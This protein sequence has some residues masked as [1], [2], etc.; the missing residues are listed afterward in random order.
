MGQT[1][2][3][4]IG[5]LSSNAD[6]VFLAAHTPVELDHRK[7]PEVGAGGTGEAKV[8]NALLGRVG[9]LERNTLVAITG[10]S[11]SGKS[12]VVR[13][14]HAQLEKN[15]QRFRILYVPRAVQTI[16]ELL[17]RIIDG[18]PGVEGAELMG[19]VD[20]AI[21][22]ST[23][24][25]MQDRL[26]AEMQ[27]ALNWSLDDQAP[28]EG[29]T[30][31]EA[32]AREDRNNL[33]GE[34]DS[35]GR[36]R[37][38]LADLLE[39]PAINKTLLRSDGNL[40]QL[41]Q[42]Y[43]SET[44]RRDDKEEIFTSD[45][46]PVRERGILGAMKGRPELRE[47]WQIIQRQPDDALDLLEEALRMALPKAL[48]LRAPGGDTLDALF[49]DSRKALRAQNEELVLIFEDLAQFGLIDGEL[50]DQ[51]VT[52]PGGDLA[53]LR[54][55][56]AVTDGAFGKMPPTVRT[57]VEHEFRV[58]ISALAEP[59]AFVGRYLNLVRVGRERTQELWQNR[60]SAGDPVKWIA[61]AC[62]TRE[63]G[64]PCRFKE[65]CHPSFGTVDISGLGEIGLYPYNENALRRAI[66]HVGENATP[67]AVL[68]QCVSEILAEADVH[69]GAGDFPHERTRAQFDFKV[70]MAKQPLLE[71]NPSSDPERAYRAIVIWGDESRLDDGILE[72]FALDIRGSDQALS[73]RET[74]SPSGAKTPADKGRAHRPP[75]QAPSPLQTLFQW[76]AGVD[77]YMPEDDVNTF[78]NTLYSLTAN[79]LNLDHALVHVHGGRGKAILD[80]LFNPTSFSI[81]GTRGRRAGANSVRFE[82][83]RIADDVGILAAARWFKDH[84]HF[85]PAKGTWEWPEGYDPAQL[86]IALEVRLDDWA[87]QVR[88]RFLNETGGS[89]I[90]RRA[91]GLRALALAASGHNPYTLTSTSSVL[92][93]DS[94]A[95]G[96]ASE[97]WRGVDEVAKRVLSQP[98]HEFIGDFAAVR[99]GE[100]GDPQLVDTWDLDR[101]V[102]E[103][104]AEPVSSLK[105]TSEAKTESVLANIAGQLLDA[106][107]A[108]ASAE[109]DAIAEVTSKFTTGL[110]GQVPAA[111]AHAALELGA[112]ANDNGLFRPQDKNSWLNFRDAA[113]VLAECES[114]LPALSIE[115]GVGDL[116]RVQ[117]Q[118]R[119]LLRMSRALDIVIN[120]M[121]ATRDECLRSGSVAGN[122]W[123]L[124]LAVKGQLSELT[125]ILRSMGPG[126]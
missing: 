59:D 28:Y 33:L 51:F 47:L 104:L 21:S 37:D 78:R 114:G 119:N 110:E 74:D 112:R 88:E 97:A 52:P 126:D 116:V 94:R 35:G 76:Q 32:A 106:M 49:R 46:L 56:F 118:W 2:F 91:I 16:R 117:S 107:S 34:R 65:T 11:G 113:D 27:I 3:S 41:V 63:A 45:D 92:E 75:G 68:D 123:E 8:L 120:S 29:E 42:S 87:A 24:G 18:L 77:A 82:L 73:R 69:I 89:E 23:P 57:R 80:A 5:A 62:D 81:E 109:S 84:G 93:A 64:R 54:V 125:D 25:E 39:I 103:F 13:W 124:G 111:V 1:V 9:D 86:M 4:D 61:N 102:Q 71:R 72:A 53:P 15:D 85:I 98:T 31:D 79:R 20:D 105:A 95:V 17:R 19:R 58:G 66:E 12:H 90:A 38:G 99:Q 10:G 83:A 115:G 14:V 96:T 67:R 22:G 40:S 6:A 122:L 70:R 50:Y 7:G 26:V 55:L 60:D 100:G 44:S 108:A 43:F 101:A 30:E 121:A 36:R 48:G